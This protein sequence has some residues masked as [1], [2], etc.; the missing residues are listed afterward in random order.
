MIMSMN[1]LLH[2]PPELETKLDEQ[3]KATG[4][5][6]EEI[7]VATLQGSFADAPSNGSPSMSLDGWLRDFDDWV[8]GHESRNPQLV[9]SRESIYPD[10]W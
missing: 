7:V 10:R 1:L 4:R 2:L 3:A 8:S 9:D 6:P 5:T